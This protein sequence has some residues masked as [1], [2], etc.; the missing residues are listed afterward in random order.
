MAPHDVRDKLRKIDELR[1]RL[2]ETAARSRPEVVREAPEA[3][4]GEPPRPFPAPGE[5]EL[6]EAGGGA[7]LRVVHRA[8]L[9]ERRGR[10]SYAAALEVAPD[11][12]ALVSRD[13]RLRD[14][15]PRRACFLDTETS[16]L[17]GGAGTFVF[18]L[19]LGFFEDDAFV[20][21][22]FLLRTPA[23]EP[24]M[25]RHVCERASA[26]DATVTFFGKNFDR[27]RVEDKIA[28][29]RIH[30]A[31]GIPWE[32]HLDL[33]HVARR[34]FGGSVESCRLTHLEHEVLGIARDDDLPG[35]ECPQAFFDFA[36]GRASHI[37]AVLAHN[38]DDILS[39]P[40]LLAHVDREAAAPSTA[41]TC[42]R[43]GRL[44]LESDGAEARDRGRELLAE[45]LALSAPRASGVAVEA[46][47]LLARDARRRGDLEAGA[48]LLERIVESRP[49]DPR[50]WLELA[51][52]REHRGHDAADALRLASAALAH[53]SGAG[54]LGESAIRRRIARLRRKSGIASEEGNS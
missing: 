4:R 8:P 7:F 19:G 22:Q 16:A 18:L 26:F 52:H 35:E 46:A 24:A 2:A 9:V 15:D 45:A 6:L 36:Q 10:E 49:A 38:R 31:K 42:L 43:I 14:F 27:V 5:A 40:S 39:L 3:Y 41:S 50:P 30:A 29:W 13:E 11:R 37:R 32:R 17:S 12:V 51:K 54:A 47:L 34:L 21:E 48:R 28:F 33:C 53:A 1:R 23:D 44:L 20:V 25:L